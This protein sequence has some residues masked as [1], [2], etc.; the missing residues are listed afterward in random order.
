[1][2]VQLEDG[3]YVS[4]DL[5]GSVNVIRNQQRDL[6]AHVKDKRGQRLGEVCAFE[7]GVNFWD[8]LEES[9]IPAQPGF[10]TVNVCEGEVFGFNAII[11]WVVFTDPTGVGPSPVTVWGRED[12]AGIL[13]PDG[14]VFYQ[15]GEY[16]TLDEFKD[17]V[18]KQHLLC[19]GV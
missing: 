7:W 18:R 2:F 6:V 11:A 5:V 3:T 17:Y 14:K 19:K 10:L 4:K 1:M 15:E 12:S 16:A 9:V 8:K 13:Q